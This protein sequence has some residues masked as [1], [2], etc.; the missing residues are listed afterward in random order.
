MCQGASLT[1]EDLIDYHKFIKK[2][3]HDPKYGE[4]ESFRISPWNCIGLKDNLFDKPQF[5]SGVLVSPNRINAKT[6]S[7]GDSAQITCRND[8]EMIRCALT[9]HQ[10]L[11]KA[12][13]QS[14][15]S[16]DHWTANASELINKH[17]YNDFV[18]NINRIYER[19]YNS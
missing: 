11:N 5:P 10:M 15:L 7:T 18:L 6:R 16:F 4:I 8:D 14:L 19:D 1:K 13:A 2:F 3:S 12:K 17:Y 9:L